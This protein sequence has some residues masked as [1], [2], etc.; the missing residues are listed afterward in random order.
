MPEPG[1]KPKKAKKAKKSAPKGEW[2]GPVPGQTVMSPRDLGEVPIGID[3]DEYARGVRWEG[4]GK[5][6]KPLPVID[7]ERH[8]EIDPHG[9]VS[10]IHPMRQSQQFRDID[11]S[12][13]DLY[14]T[15]G[16]SLDDI[17]TVQ[18]HWSKQPVTSVRSDS[19]VH[20]V[21]WHRD[22][23]G[24]GSISD[25]VR[26]IEAGGKIN[27]PAWLVRDKGKLFVLDGHHRI[28]AARRA[29]L[30]SYPARIWDRDAETGWKP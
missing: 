30:E 27:N 21:Q 18:D 3:T 10:Q 6:R 17:P 23:E 11:K 22:T 2:S 26:D 8:T 20:T 24:T 16:G 1:K 12:T 25:I 5:D 7:R 4:S 28:T 14:A 13:A 19:P 9:F 15:H 29:G